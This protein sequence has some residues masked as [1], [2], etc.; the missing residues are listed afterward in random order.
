MMSKSQ[1]FEDLLTETKKEAFLQA[2]GWLDK[3]ERQEIPGVEL[4]TIFDTDRGALKFLEKSYTTMRPIIRYFLL[5]ETIKTGKWGNFIRRGDRAFDESGQ[6][7]VATNLVDTHP[8][9]EKLHSPTDEEDQMLELLEREMMKKEPVVVKSKP[10]SPD[11]SKI[12]D[13]FK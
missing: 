3:P 6:V 9:W 1:E 7:Y 10:V 8:F 2:R 5:Q 4:V 13:I 12:P 11:Y